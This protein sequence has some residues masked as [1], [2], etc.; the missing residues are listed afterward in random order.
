VTH[1]VSCD[2]G[3][4]VVRSDVLCIVIQ[5]SDLP[6]SSL[7]AY[8]SFCSRQ[9]QARFPCSGVCPSRS[10]RCFVPRWQV[11]AK[12]GG[13]HGSGREHGGAAAI[14]HSSSTGGAVQ[15]G[16]TAAR[17]GPGARGLLPVT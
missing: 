11:L 17:A 13:L 15:R 4:G 8:A 10:R 12:E 6:D 14:G 1:H 5:S 16:G 3:Q 7:P 9:S 2:A